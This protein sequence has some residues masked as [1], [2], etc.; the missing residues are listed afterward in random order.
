MDDQ[1]AVLTGLAGA[2]LAEGGAIVPTV[3][4]GTD[5][6]K[7]LVSLPAFA[8]G[9]HLAALLPALSLLWALGCSRII[10]SFTGR[11][12]SL[13]D[14][15]APVLEDG[16]DMRQHVLIIADVTAA[17][18]TTH[19]IPIDGRE[20][21]TAETITTSGVRGHIVEMMRTVVTGD[22]PDPADAVL[23]LIEQEQRMTASGYT[24]YYRAD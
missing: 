15:I 23:L 3:V 5:T 8:A 12:W 24:I 19:I 13:K 17:E 18:A 4:G 20:L 7:A 21:R 9:E 1:V 11:A 22:S 10:A 14:P 16:A 6:P 2:E